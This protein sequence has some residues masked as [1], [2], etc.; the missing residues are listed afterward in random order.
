MRSSG[1]GLDP[2]S[3][4]APDALV[5]LRSFPRRWRSVLAVLADDPEAAELV[6]RRPDPSSWSVVEHAWYVADL[7]E[8]HRQRVERTRASE[9][10]VLADDDPLR[11]PD[12]RGYRRRELRAALDAITEAATGL[13]A[14]LERLQGD[15]WLRVARVG[16][17][18]VT[19][20]DMARHAV[21]ESAYHLRAAERTVRAV[22]GRP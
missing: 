12:E 18:D 11:W 9:R 21:H 20:L 14:T 3:I 19:L 4:T 6:R 8:W 2:A 16:D 13:A 22:R 17:E 1:D 15:D 5:A 7:L 10:P